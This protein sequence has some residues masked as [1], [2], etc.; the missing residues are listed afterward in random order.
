MT[1]NPNY[2]AVHAFVDEMWRA[3]VRHVCI[4]PGSR[5][6]PLTI[7]IAEHGGFEIYTLLDERSSAFFAVGLARRAAVPVALVCT[8][9]TATANY[10]P[11]IMEAKQSRVP[12]LVLT[13]DRPPELHDIGQ[14]QTVRQ[15]GMY[16]EHVKWNVHMPVPDGTNSVTT[17]AAA[18]AWRAVT[19]ATSAPAGPVHV[20][21]PFREPLVPAPRKETGDNRRTLRNLNVG[22]LEIEDQVARQI[23]SLWDSATQPLVVLGP[24]EDSDFARLLIRLCHVMNTPLLAD[25]LSQARQAGAD[26]DERQCVIDTYDWFVAP[27]FEDKVSP[28]VVFRFGRT[29]TSKGLNQFLGK[30]N[31]RQ[32]VVS[33]DYQWLDATLS[34]TDVIISNGASLVK[35]WVELEAPEAVNRIGWLSLWKDLNQSAI[36]CVD[37][38]ALELPQTEGDWA[39][40]GRLW[41]ELSQVLE[42]GVNLFVGNSMPVRDLDG[43]F[44]TSGHTMNVYANRGVS[45]IDGVVSSAVGTSAAHQGPTLLVIGD[46]SFYHDLNGLY[47]SSAYGL[48]LVVVL[49][50]NDGG[51][52]FT[53]LPQAEHPNTFSYFQTRHGLDYRGVTE[54]YQGEFIEP[55]NWNEFQDA[56]RNGL[57]FAG[58]TVIQ[59]RTSGEESTLHRRKI[60]RLVQFEMDDIIR[61]IGTGSNAL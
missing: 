29:P 10:H 45:G 15:I 48:P 21:W 7:S 16:G 14:N 57:Q 5:S 9:G 13:A 53:G 22:K 18:T 28:D 54:T 58:L 51:G 49:V 41:T 24:Q 40:E 60:K 2:E 36:R 8:S 56:V 3:G 31:A 61:R 23:F 47:A 12:L 38:A 33:D 44:H 27:G 42:S 46:V 19:Q 6:T 39:F 4:S 17:F 52:I 37:H 1:T 35:K 55:K 30:L 11:G 25:G 20:N 50:H 59:L 32:V 26:S 34:A 43:F